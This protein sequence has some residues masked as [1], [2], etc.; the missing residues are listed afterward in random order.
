MTKIT[1]TFTGKNSLGYE[2]GQTYTLILIHMDIQLEN[3][4]N[5]CPYGSIEA[6]LNNWNNIKV[7]P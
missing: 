6:F 1:A 3:G 7:V 2:H 5:Y 4:D